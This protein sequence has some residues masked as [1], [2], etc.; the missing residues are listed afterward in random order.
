MALHR[1]TQAKNGSL[2]HR[3]NLVKGEARAVGLAIAYTWTH[4]GFGM[5]AKSVQSGAF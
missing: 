1:V 4:F 5:E 2:S 3:L